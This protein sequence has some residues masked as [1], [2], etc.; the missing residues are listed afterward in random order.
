MINYA[1]KIK[2]GF[3]KNRRTI[4]LLLFILSLALSARLIFLDKIPTGMSDDE[5]LYPL[6]S[7]SFFYTGKDLSEQW[8]TFSLS[9]PSASV[10]NVYGRVPYIIFSPYFASINLSMFT[11][12]LP[13]ALLG[14]FFVLVMFAICRKL[15]STKIALVVS[16]MTAINPWSIFFS[17]TAYEAP[18]ATY[19]AFLMLAI[20]LYSKSWKILF[21]L[22][23]YIL[24]FYSYLGTNIILPVFTIIT[25]VYSWILNKKQNLNIYILFT[26]VISILLVFYIVHLP[27][28]IG[29]NRT[30]ELLTPNSQ[31]IAS[32][33]NWNRR[34]SIKTPAMGLFINKYEDSA[35]LFISQYLGAFSPVYLFSQ[36]D[37]AARFTLW[38][39]GAFYI[40]D[41]LFLAIGLFELL[42]NR[43]RE[44]FFLIS[45]LL[46]APIPSAIHFG[47]SQ[48][49][50]RSAFMFP[51]LLIFIGYG[52]YA[53]INRFK[54]KL[55]P[56]LAVVFVYS[57]FVANFGYVYLFRNPIYN[58]DS[59]GISG[60]ILSRY[61]VLAGRHG[62]K[63][64]VLSNGVNKG[65]FKQYLFFNN[66]YTWDNH[67]LI[68]TDFLKPKV[69]INNVTFADCKDISVDKSEITVIPFNLKCSSE[70]LSLNKLDL[71][72]YTDNQPIYQIY[73][74]ELC[75]KY[76]VLPYLNN[77]SLNDF[78]IEKLSEQ[79]FCQTFFT[80][81]LGLNSITSTG[82]AVP[83]D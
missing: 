46:L 60:R 64:Q 69:N 19:F 15:F 66:N 45:L 40:I 76:S 77:F 21:A 70:K 20:L 10:I 4:L 12:R 17:R 22:P 1:N 80:R 59:F 52:I 75:K 29:G 72:N 68:A 51:I 41:A 35:R 55:I 25:L 79:K 57:I 6:Q 34:E 14:A 11:A 67:S 62:Y 63:V 16:L 83:V 3:F 18:I 33:V 74:D 65:L 73:N 2:K 30:S 42:K 53:F 38:D 32:E 31:S 82:S 78:N 39:H 7:R 48:Y 5:A 81:I 13:Y 23:I 61:I 26:V 28:D 43:R 37:G 24:S 36:G 49:A 47:D 27:N 9:K 58:Y 56:I 44:G 71:T 50:L 8:S 54:N